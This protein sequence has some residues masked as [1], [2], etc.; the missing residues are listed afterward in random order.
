M[1]TRIQKCRILIVAVAIGILPVWESDARADFV[2]GIPVNLGPPINTA[3]EETPACI[4]AD[5]LEFYLVC[6]DRPGGHG[7]SDLWVSKRTTTADKWGEPVNLG[8]TVNTDGEDQQ[9]SITSDGLELY[10]NSD[11]SGGMGDWDIWVSRR[12]SRDEPWEEPILLGPTINTAAFETGVVSGD[13]LNLYLNLIGQQGGHGAVDI[14]LSTRATRDE[15]WSMPVNLGATVNSAFHEAMNSISADSLLLV[16][17]DL[18]GGLQPNGLGDRDI[19]MTTRSNAVETWRKAINAG[20]SINSSFLD[21]PAVI[22]TEGHSLYLKSD[23]PGGLGGGD[24]WKASIEPVVDFNRDGKVDAQDMS[25]LVYHWHTSDPLCDI[26]PP[27]WGD[28]IVDIQDMS[29]LSEY[30]DPGFGRIAHWKLDETEGNVA[31]DSIG[32]DHANVHG[33]AVWQPDIGML[34]GALAL[35]GVDDYIAPML[36][37]NPMDKPFRILAWVKGG[38]PGQVIASQTPD[39][40]RPGSAYLAADPDDGTLLTGMMLS[41][42]PLDSDV[43]ITD[44]EWH[45]VGLEWDGERRHLMVNDDQVAVDEVTLPALD[46][47]GYL[48]IGTGPEN[49]PGS[50]WSGLIDDVRVYKK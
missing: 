28:G 49:E 8:P 29:V 38:A 30:L 47:T 5:G 4:S 2:F 13:G 3:N 11:R 10:F 25:I 17:C 9:A 41:N 35:D 12:A 27:P 43:A 40:F 24:I 42:M 45:E 7:E 19:W 32:S 23:R 44:D 39:E 26:G 33:E 50:F 20:T 15:A 48:N 1:K 18:A 46:Y 14:W 16:F 21:G 22:S 36:I 31:Y 34:A 6:R 37:L